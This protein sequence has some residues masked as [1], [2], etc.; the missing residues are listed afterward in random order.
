MTGARVT[1]TRLVDAFPSPR[2]VHTGVT[3]FDHAPN[4]VSIFVF[5]V[6]SP[7]NTETEQYA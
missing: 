3:Q 6:S 5:K 7:Y 1:D 4:L 2:R